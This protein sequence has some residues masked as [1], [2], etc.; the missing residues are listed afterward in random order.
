VTPKRVPR[1]SSYSNP[2]LAPTPKVVSSRDRLPSAPP[3]VFTATVLE[4]LP[5]IRFRLAPTDSFSSMR[6]AIDGS[7]DTPSS[8]PSCAR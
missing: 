8:V 6:A 1:L 3:S 4:S 2:R 7:T 5:Y